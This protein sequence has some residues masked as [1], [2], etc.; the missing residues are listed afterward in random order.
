MS[1]PNG[2]DEPVPGIGPFG[3]RHLGLTLTAAQ[4]HRSAATVREDASLPAYRNGE[5]TPV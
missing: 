1:A 4:P 5:P 2:G 3:L